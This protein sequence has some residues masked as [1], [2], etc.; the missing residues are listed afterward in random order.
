MTSLCD[1]LHEELFFSYFNS[2]H[3]IE[4]NTTRLHSLVA[5]IHRVL[6]E[7]ANRTGEP[8]ASHYGLPQFTELSLTC[9]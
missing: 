6:E 3:P 8:R 9:V 5:L 7:V 2:T 4:H 1:N